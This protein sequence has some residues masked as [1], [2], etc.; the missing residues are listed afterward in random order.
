MDWSDIGHNLT[1]NWVWDQ[2][3]YNINQICHWFSY[4]IAP[5][6]GVN[7]HLFKWEPAQGTGRTEELENLMFIGSD[8]NSNYFFGVGVNAVYG[9]P[10]GHST[11]EP[12]D[13]FEFRIRGCFSTE[14]YL[15]TLFT[16][17]FTAVTLLGFGYEHKVR[18]N[19][20][21]GI[22][23]HSYFKNGFYDSD[24][25]KTDNWQLFSVFCKLKVR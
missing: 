22:S 25:D 3:E 2:D 1:S 21:A 10:F 19:L 4:F 24:D 7:Y 8:L 23:Y 5:L 12:F 16:D 11:K 20:Y 14:T 18:K 9:K 17:G 13:S 15:V 6:E